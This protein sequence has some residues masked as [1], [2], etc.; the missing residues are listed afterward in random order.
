[1]VSWRHLNWC[2]FAQIHLSRG[3]WRKPKVALFNELR[4]HG[5]S[6]EAITLPKLQSSTN[7][8]WTYNEVEDHEFISKS[9]V[10]DWEEVLSD[11]LP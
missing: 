4:L 10:N 7:K 9:L 11:G 3:I 5:A 1:M 2:T 8:K 6:A